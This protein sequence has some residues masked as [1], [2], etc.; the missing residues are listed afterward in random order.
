MFLAHF[1]NSALAAWALLGLLLLFVAGMALM[2]RRLLVK[3]SVAVFAIGAVL[4]LALLALT[5]GEP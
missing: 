2:K 5:V 1:L 4:L 3:D